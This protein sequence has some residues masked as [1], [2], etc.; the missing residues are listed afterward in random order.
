MIDLPGSLTV[1]GL[2][3]LRSFVAGLGDWLGGLIP[4]AVLDAHLSRRLLSWL[5]GDVLQHSGAKPRS[6]GGLVV[7]G[8]NGARHQVKILVR[9]EMSN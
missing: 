8:K 2:L 7:D 5:L 3:L 1:R 9:P 6:F 4:F